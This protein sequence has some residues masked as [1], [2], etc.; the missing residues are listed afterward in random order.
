MVFGRDF[1]LFFSRLSPNVILVRRFGSVGV[2]EVIGRISLRNASAFSMDF[3]SKSRSK[4]LRGFLVSSASGS[5]DFTSRFPFTLRTR[6][7]E[8][9]I[10]HMSPKS[11]FFLKKKKIK[12]FLKPSHF[13]LFIPVGIKDLNNIP[14]D[15]A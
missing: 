6:L 2:F 1:D 9:W 15:S 13:L 12:I 5:S 7:I 14:S 10:T 3:N 8:L 4:S 11:I